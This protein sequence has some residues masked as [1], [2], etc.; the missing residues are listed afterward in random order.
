MT[1]TLIKSSSYFQSFS[2]QNLKM[3]AKITKDVATKNPADVAGGSVGSGSVSDAGKTMVAPG[4]GGDVHISRDA[5]ESNPK[6]FFD[7]LHN[8]EKK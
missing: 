5:F 4:S 8:K 7:D 6:K 2:I 3:D 1:H